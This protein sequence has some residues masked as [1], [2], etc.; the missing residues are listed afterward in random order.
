MASS[1]HASDSSFKQKPLRGAAS[2]S[3]SYQGNV[4]KPWVPVLGISLSWQPSFALAAESASGAI[5]EQLKSLAGDW[6]S[7][8]NDSSTVVNYK[9]IASGSSLVETW[10]MS[11]TRQSMTVYTMDGE[12][13]IATHYCPQGN[14]PRL[15]FTHTDKDGAHHFLFLDGA[16]LQDPT[17][18]HEHAFWIMIDPSGALTRSET[19]IDN[20][21]TYN[22]E[23]D[24]GDEAS[25]IRLN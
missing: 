1:K 10:T 8:R 23:L 18:S 21:A 6:R 13:L 22:P 3:S 12:R 19:Y 17:G 20:G 9:V 14:A 4:M 2:S 5:F 24:K 11:P 16:N 25:F 7:T 15:Q